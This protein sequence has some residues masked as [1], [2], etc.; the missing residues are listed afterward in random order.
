MKFVIRSIAASV[1]AVSVIAT[2]AYAS[3]AIEEEATSKAP[4]KITDRSHPDYVRCR[5]ESIIGSLARKR[6]V[7]MTNKE[8]AK[9][10]RQGNRDSRQFV[11]DGQ[12]GMNQSSFPQS[13]LDI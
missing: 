9:V 2:P 6:R 4:E 8:W 5:T 7:C 13:D 11:E 1:F 10:A 3:G 12:A